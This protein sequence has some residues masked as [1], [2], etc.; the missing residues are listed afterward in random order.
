MESQ[1]E[2]TTHEVEKEEPFRPRPAKAKHKGHGGAWKVAYADFV[3]AMMALFIVLWVLSQDEKVKLAVQAYFEDPTGF[4]KS[5]GAVVPVGRGKATPAPETNMQDALKRE[6]EREASRIRAVL[7][8]NPALEALVDQI[9]VEVT[10][11]GIRME[12]RDA[13]KFSFFDIGSAVVK[14]EL[15]RSLEVLAP[16]FSRLGYPVVI[17]G[18]TDSRPYGTPSYSNWEL[19]ADRAAAVRRVLI[20]KGLDP[21]RITEVRSYADTRLLKPEDPLAAENRRVSILLKRSLPPTPT[22][23]SVPSQPSSKAPFILKP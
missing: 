14:P 7:S 3:T 6:L 13:P 23:V 1:P 18:H 10:D 22:P 19:S 12:F 21:S 5:G 11:E 20:N 2:R 15:E 17:E 16:E 4:I 8:Q 9:S